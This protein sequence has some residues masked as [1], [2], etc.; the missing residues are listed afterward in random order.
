MAIL[1]QTSAALIEQT[2]NR[3]LELDAEAHSKLIQFNNKIIHL[4]ITDLDLNYYFIFPSSNLIVRTQCERKPAASISG[5]L[6]AFIGAATANNSGDSLFTGDLHFS[7]DINTARHFQEFVQS[8]DMDWQ[9]PFS[10][11]FGDFVGQ[12]IT[13][14]LSHA[15]QF[16]QSLV[17]TVAQ[18]VPEYLQHEIQVTPTPIELNNFFSDVDLLRSQ[19]DRLQARINRIQAHD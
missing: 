6:T 9:E 18:D 3:L 15:G 2:A 4:F 10:D 14:G 5:N 12:S 16:F 17:E 11:F 8:L 7:G 1:N 13:Q 19:T